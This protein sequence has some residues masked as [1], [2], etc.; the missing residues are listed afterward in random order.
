VIRLRSPWQ[1]MIFCRRYLKSFP[2]RGTTR[3]LLTRSLRSD[4][5]YLSPAGWAWP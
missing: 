3:T 1:L 5:V 4:S 2:Y